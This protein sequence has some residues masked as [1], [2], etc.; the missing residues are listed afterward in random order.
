MS[1]LIEITKQLHRIE[2]QILE[3]NG[4][5]TPELELE[6]TQ[7]DIAKAQKIDAYY[8]IMKRCDILSQAYRAEAD[9]YSR[10]AK[11]FDR[12]EEHLKETLK[13]AMVVTGNQEI[14]GDESAFKLSKRPDKVEIY[15]EK[16]L[17]DMYKR[18]VLKYEI[19]KEKLKE[20]L[21]RGAQVPGARLASVIALLP[22]IRKAQI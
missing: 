7:V 1:S 5:L 17:P 9:K 18:P 20:D 16:T 22:Q 13:M 3:N 2:Q 12:I 10:M 21:S 4:E 14:S 11:G 8:A 6:F 19:D 15:D